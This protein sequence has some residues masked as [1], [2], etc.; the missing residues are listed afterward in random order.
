MPK[1]VEILVVDDEPRGVE[2]LKR[3]LRRMGTVTTALSAEEGWKA[4]QET[5]FDL[6]IS[7]QRMPGE[8][9]VELL[10]RVAE[11]E[12]SPGR[13]LLTGYADLE[14]SID[15]INCGRVHAY[16]TKPCAPEQLQASALTVLE[17]V[18]LMRENAEL[19]ASLQLKN[20]ALEEAFVELQDA[21]RRVLSSERLAAIGQMIA[22]IVH[23]FRGPLTVIHASGTE[24][25][26]KAEESD[27][28]E[29]QD[30]SGDIQ[31][32]ALR[33]Q[34]MC[35]ELLD[36]TRAS[37]GDSHRCVEDFDEVVA[38]ALAGIAR[39]ATQAG[40][41]L[42]LDLHS[43]REVALDEDRIRRAILNLGYNAIE[44][45][46]EGGALRIDSESVGDR[47]TLRIA[48]NGKGIPDE[49]RDRL[50]DPFV[51]SGKANGSGLGLAV[52][53]K[54]VDDHEGTIEVTKPEG[55]GTVFQICLPVAGASNAKA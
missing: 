20:S 26:R 53:K 30:L 48:D 39:D 49:I 41:A 8:S 16:L 18:R 2:L 10:S 38:S 46:P 24:V 32:E 13:I 51:T 28:A 33:M 36:V 27:D 47:V 54:V 15:A 29:L 11:Q 23:D 5:E 31:S 14:A 19:L 45:M 25:T 40:V 7:D 9:G 44:A 12:H 17:Q 1:P 50:F 22:M 37:K 52:V 43:G 55:G 42:E 4:A 34:R 21:Q 6:V 35:A 3:M